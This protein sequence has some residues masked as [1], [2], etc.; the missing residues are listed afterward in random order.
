MNS[1]ILIIGSNS[2]ENAIFHKF[3]KNPLVKLYCYSTFINPQIETLCEKYIIFD[4]GDT[5]EEFIRKCKHTCIFYDIKYI[6][7][8][9]EK[10]LVTDIVKELESINK[11]CIAPNKDQAKIET[12]KIFAR[13]CLIEANLSVCNPEFLII[14][15]NT[16]LRN[17]YRF[18]K[19]YNNEIVIKPHSP[20]SGKGVLVYGDHL[21]SFEDIIEC[22]TELLEKK[23]TLL[24]EEKLVGKEFSL[25]TITDGKTNIH[26]S[27]VCDF[28]RLNNNDKG[29]NTGS[30]GCITEKKLWF[31][32]EEDIK[33]AQKINDVILK[34]LNDKGQ[35]DIS[36]NSRTNK[37]YK[38]FLYG[39]FIK[40]IS[41]EIKVIEFNA[42]LGDPEAIPIVNELSID[43]VSLCNHIKLQTLD[44]IKA[45]CLDAKSSICSY[46]VPKNYPDSKASFTF[47]LDNLTKEEMKY[48][49]FSSVEE[50]TIEDDE[51][52]NEK[53]IGLTSRTLAIYVEHD[54]LELANDIIINIQ[55]KIMKQNPG[56]FHCRTDLLKR[57]HMDNKNDLYKGVG[58]DIGGGDNIV[59]EISGLVK[60]TYNKNVLNEI[61]SFGGCFG[62]EDIQ[63]QYD[64][65]VLVSSIDGVGTKSIVSIKYSG[66]KGFNY[67]G[68]DIVN[69]CINDILVQGAVPL[70]FMDYIASSKLKEKEVVE[71]VKG[72]TISCRQYNCALLG[73][74]TAEMPGIYTDSNYDFVGCITGVVDKKN[75]INGVQNIKEGDIM[76]GIPSS[77]LHT[78]GYSLIRKLIE[79]Y[80][81]QITD[82]MKTQLCAPH[83]CYLNEIKLIQE[84]K[85][86]IHG[87]CHITGGGFG[88]ISR[89]LDKSLTYHFNN[90]QYSPLFKNI[91]KI[92]NISKREMEKVFNCGW[93]MIIIVTD[94]NA[95]N[96]IKILPE[97][98]ILGE[99]VRK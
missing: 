62:L 85:M 96:I 71:F 22:V 35:F 51:L 84:H 59:K 30:M 56:K 57:Y 11:F 72:I 33:E 36:F 66:E 39:S 95:K 79:D 58:V 12:D 91:Q 54:C 94:I 21:H 75:I 13:Q 63:K 92:G 99:I 40:T 61:G 50:I 70:Y 20:C 55:Q 27:P 82:E 2:R 37:F 43:F 19:Q 83:R 97:T 93:G 89:V 76:V 14:D 38:G 48:I 65:P 7:I 34:L 98:Q 5:E 8:G 9:S 86:D 28:K 16:D 49:Y 17:I 87:L 69:H 68:Q 29:V 53:Y 6:I 32:D 25:I 10:Y 15:S 24:M 60:S 73:G 90:L 74:E 26:T 18:I 41:G 44:E 67:L 80:P 47:N 42:R 31:L 64:N 3:A 88:N 77:G 52:M 4:K 23:Q 1:N 46:M 45:N 81:N 78:N